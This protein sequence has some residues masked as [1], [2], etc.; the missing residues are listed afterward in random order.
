MSS[1]ITAA[2]DRVFRAHSR[3]TWK[4]DED[5]LFLLLAGLHSLDDKLTADH[6]R[7]LSEIP[8]YRVLKS[9]RNYFHHESELRSAISIASYA[10]EPLIVELMFVCLV[11]CAD[12]AKAVEAE[13]AKY[14]E[15]TSAAFDQVLK[16]YGDVA[17]INPAIF[18]CMVKVLE[19]LQN[20]GLSGESD[21]FAMCAESYASDL[22]QGISPYV[23]GDIKVLPSAA[24]DVRA[25]LM[26]LY[27]T[28]S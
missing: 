6:G 10:K 18:N 4:R 15:A 3:Y 7:L 2:I 22:E 23:S 9:L 5:S 25:C 12:C 27:R 16:I 11:S 26:R 8:E 20:L 28:Q 21:E 17:D 19:V 13:S 14:R 24:E 1:T